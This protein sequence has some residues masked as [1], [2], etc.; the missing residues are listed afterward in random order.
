M[1]S[2]KN[3]FSFILP[4]FIL[5]FSLQF[6][7][8]LNRSVK[9][10]ENSLA[11]EYAIVV[12]SKKAIENKDIKSKIPFISSLNEIKKDSYIERLKGDMSSA[13][14]AYLK[15]T[16]PKFYS[17]KLTKLPNDDELQV[18]TDAIHNYKNVQKVETFKQTFNKFHRYLRFSKSASYIF[19][20]FIFFIS[21]LLIIKQM[22]IWT[23]EH[24]NR[25]YVMGLFGAPFWMKSASLYKSVIIDSVI[26]A[27]LVGL[28]FYL[29]PMFVDLAKIRNDLGLELNNFKLLSDTLRLIFL[30]LIISIIA[31]TVTILRQKDQ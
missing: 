28:L 7:F 16:L 20:I 25:M 15:A 12:V 23:L 24:Q 10:Y 2:I 1:K 17:V 13:D 26:S 22:E 5:L 29:M 27:I 14:L 21:I 4:L 31:V 19:T 11:D 3:H 8:M 9:A 6:S 30:S 18:I